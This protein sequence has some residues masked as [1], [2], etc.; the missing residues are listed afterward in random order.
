MLLPQT[1]ELEGTHM[2]WLS[3]FSPALILFGFMVL[4]VVIEWR[5]LHRR[6]PFLKE[7]GSVFPLLHITRPRDSQAE[8]HRKA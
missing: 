4:I 7:E 8:V 6:R 5:T 3:V 1:D 2:A